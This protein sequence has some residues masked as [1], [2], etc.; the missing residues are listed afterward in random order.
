MTVFIVLFK[1]Y[2]NII[3]HS[4]LGMNLSQLTYFFGTELMPSIECSIVIIDQ[5]TVIM[6]TVIIMRQYKYIKG[7]GDFL[8]ALC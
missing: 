8:S 6:K 3:L 4:I 7:S 2:N 1:N 5:Y